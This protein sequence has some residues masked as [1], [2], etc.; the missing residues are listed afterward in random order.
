LAWLTK[1]VLR[2]VDSL[3]LRG[4]LV[5]VVDSP[6]ATGRHPMSIFHADEGRRP[7]ATIFNR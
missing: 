4:D 2:A 6:W 5:V 7:A 3:K 1:D